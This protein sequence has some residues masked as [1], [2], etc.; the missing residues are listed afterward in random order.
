MPP[1][2]WAAGRAGAVAGRGAA[3]A[4]WVRPVPIVSGGA[5]PPGHGRAAADEAGGLG[6]ARSPS[7]VPAGPVAYSAPPPPFPLVSAGRSPVPAAS[8][9]GGTRAASHVWRSVLLDPA[10]LVSLPLCALG[11]PRHTHPSTQPRGCAA[12]PPG[13]GFP[14]FQRRRFQRFNFYFGFLGSPP[15]SLTAPGLDAA[16]FS[17]FKNQ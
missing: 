7:P 8:P 4:P 13:G 10:A 9:R 2:P 1:P 11:V 14:Q 6:T 12:S 3:V 16:C 17:G 5:R 15:L